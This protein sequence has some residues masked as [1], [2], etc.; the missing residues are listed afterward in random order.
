MKIE[1]VRNAKF[2][3]KTPIPI[4][5]NQPNHYRLKIPLPA[6]FVRTQLVQSSSSTAKNSFDR[7]L[8]ENLAPQLIIRSDLAIITTARKRKQM[9]LSLPNH[10]ARCD[11][12][13]LTA[14]TISNPMMMPS[15]FRNRTT[16]ISCIRKPGHNTLLRICMQRSDQVCCTIL[17]HMLTCNKIKII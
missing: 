16:N 2:K 8:P 1:L 14:C 15:T 7:M 13:Q 12:S 11:T 10:A 4:R 6:P 9:R 5:V 3:H 17:D